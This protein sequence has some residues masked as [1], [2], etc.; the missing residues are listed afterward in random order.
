MGPRNGARRSKQL[1][2]DESN[3][4]EVVIFGRLNK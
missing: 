1:H 4:H 3:L 2:P